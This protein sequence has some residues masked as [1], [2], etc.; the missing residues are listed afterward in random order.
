MESLKH[1]QYL[2]LSLA[3]WCL[4]FVAKDIQSCGV[5]TQFNPKL[6]LYFLHK[7]QRGKCEE[8]KDLTESVL[9]EELEFEEQELAEL[10]RPAAR[11]LIHDP[12]IQA[13]A[14]E[15]THLWQK[16]QGGRVVCCLFTQD[17]KN[18]VKSFEGLLRNTG[19]AYDQRQRLCEQ[20]VEGSQLT[21]I[22]ARN[23]TTEKLATGSEDP[24]LHP[25]PPKVRLCKCGRPGMDSSSSSSAACLGAVDPQLQH[26]IEVETQKQRFQQLVH[27]MT[28]LCWEKCM[29]KPGPKLDSRAEA[30]FVN[31]VERFIDT[32][33]FIVNQL[34]QTQK[35]KPAF[36]E[37]LSD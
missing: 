7:L 36:S 30:C 24:Y 23:L 14:E 29:D 16:I 34:E 32:S 6:W 5:L 33:R 1:G 13:Q 12:F 2:R 21:E 9:E 15:L 25:S 18:T 10:L 3:T 26:F 19:I 27:Q 17:V 35:S 28:E 20:M 4:V 8:D 37:S 11:L 31:C 22:L